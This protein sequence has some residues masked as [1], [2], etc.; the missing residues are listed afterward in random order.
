[1]EVPPLMFHGPDG[2][3]QP[4]PD[5][6]DPCQFSERHGPPLHGCEVVD[7]RDG[8]HRVERLIAEG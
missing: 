3:E 7:H 2:E 8:Q 1:M 6:G 5:S 4:P